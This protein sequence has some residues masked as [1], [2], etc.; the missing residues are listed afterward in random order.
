MMFDAGQLLTLNRPMTVWHNTR[1]NDNTVVMFAL[2][3]DVM[4][5]FQ[6]EDIFVRVLSAFGVGYVALNDLSGN[7]TWV[8]DKT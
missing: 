8:D 4:L 6:E 2:E 3:D 7:V 5:V 1:M